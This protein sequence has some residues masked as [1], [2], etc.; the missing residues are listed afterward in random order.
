M[1][2]ISALLVILSL[3]I[4]FMPAAASPRERV[5]DEITLFTPPITFPA[6]TP[7]PLAH[8]FAFEKGDASG[9]RGAYDHQLEVDG[10]PVSA[11]FTVRERNPDDPTFQDWLWVYNFPAGLPAGNHIL[12]GHWFYPCQ[13]AVDLGLYPGPCDSPLDPVEVRTRTAVIAFLP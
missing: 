3:A 8:G 6:D 10:A 13:E 1:R 4:N 12:A 2:K 5:G 11:D 7:F 9:S